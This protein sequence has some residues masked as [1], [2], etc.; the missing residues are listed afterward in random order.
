[1]VV[2]FIRKLKQTDLLLAGQD[3]KR[4][5]QALIFVSHKPE[6][7]QKNSLLLKGSKSEFFWE[8]LAYG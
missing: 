8:I 5:R 7:P 4:D 1:M 2:R 3:K 6:F